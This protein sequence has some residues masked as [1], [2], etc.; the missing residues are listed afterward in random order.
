MQPRGAPRGQSDACRAPVPAPDAATAGSAGQKKQLLAPPAKMRSLARRPR[1]GCRLRRPPPRGL[2]RPTLTFRMASSM[3]SCRGAR[4][5]R[6]WI[7]ASWTRTTSS[8]RSCFGARATRRSIRASWTRATRRWWLRRGSGV[9]GIDDA[10]P[11]PRSG[12]F[13]GWR[14]RSRTSPRRC[15]RRADDDGRRAR[16]RALRPLPAP[17]AIRGRRVRR[18][19]APR[20][21]GRGHPA[22]APGKYAHVVFYA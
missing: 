10:V 13:V 15:R 14:R 11:A 6:R 17:R 1:S 3:R 20:R 21:G 8:T 22:C 5:T 12:V 4:A 9:V 18:G 16:C 19:A 7:R 2:P